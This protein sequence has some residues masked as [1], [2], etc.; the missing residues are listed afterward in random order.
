MKSPA[1]RKFS[2]LDLSI[3]SVITLVF[4]FPFPLH[5]LFQWG[6]TSLV[7]GPT[8]NRPF[9]KVAC[10]PMDPDIVWALTS[11]L[12]DPTS[13]IIDPA[14]G[15]YKSTDQGLTWTQVNDAV[16]RP[17]INAL[18]IA[19]SHI[20]S[21]VV[22]IATN[23][24]GIFKTTDGGQSWTAVNNGIVYNSKSFPESTWAALAVAVDPT[25]DDIVYCGVANANN[26]DYLSGTGDHPGFFKS[27]DGGAT[28]TAHNQGLPAR[29]DPITFFDSVSHTSTV[30]SIA[31]IPQSPNIVVIGMSDQE[32][33]VAAFGDRTARSSGRMFFST[34]RATGNWTELSAGLPQV[35]QGGGFLDL[36]RV[37]FSQLFLTAVPSGAPGVYASHLG[38][39]AD[40]YI[41]TTTA[42]SKSRGVYHYENG[43]WVRRSTGL[44]VVTDDFNDGATNAGPVAVSPV[45]PDI[46]L[47]G[48][49]L[50]DSGDP[51]S[52]RSKVYA[53]GS[54]GT[55]W[56][57]NWD[58]GL[59]NSPNYGYTEADA[60]FVS[61]NADQSAAFASVI[62]GDGT[63][64][65]DGI[66]RLPPP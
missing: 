48:V 49:S 45:N 53:S 9:G 56:S 57:G 3:L 13:N 38:G 27:T 23:V 29:S 10:D 33:N 2:F 14:Q 60:G 8:E 21:N 62:W 61:I 5:A 59:S 22:Y 43:T 36:A 18:D 34:D 44:P 1:N 55:L 31:V 25:D 35:S 58:T 11:H 4:L 47:V 40:V 26:V 46:M 16:L 42:K 24:E 52:D 20:N 30:A 65:D 63:G 39:S 17:E 41:D 12:P 15:V 7:N 37:S 50:S 19:I 64:P 28:W 51:Y 66:Y 54:G 6:P 32:V